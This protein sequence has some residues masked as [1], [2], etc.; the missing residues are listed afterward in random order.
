MLVYTLITKSITW[1]FKLLWGF[2]AFLKKK[3]MLIP[4]FL[5]LAFLC[6]IVYFVDGIGGNPEVAVY[7]I[8]PILGYGISAGILPL[9][10]KLAKPLDFCRVLWYN[11]IIR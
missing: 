3:K 4:F 7:I 2:F 10:R 8:A 5:I 6:G 9:K 1:T 11:G